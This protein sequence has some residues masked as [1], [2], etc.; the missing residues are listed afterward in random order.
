MGGS[1]GCVVGSV[2]EKKDVQV[3]FIK[4]TLILVERWGRK[5][6]RCPITASGSWGSSLAFL[7]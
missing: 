6:E 7:D 4:G 5:E 2:E 3:N 1:G